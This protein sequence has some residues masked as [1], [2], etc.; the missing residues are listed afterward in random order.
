M[1]MGIRGVGGVF[2]GVGRCGE[3]FVRVEGWV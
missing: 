2:E 1:G 3:G